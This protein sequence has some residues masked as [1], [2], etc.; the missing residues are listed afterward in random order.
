[1]FIEVVVLHVLGTMDS[2]WPLL[3]QRIFVLTN[4]FAEFFDVQMYVSI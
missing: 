1:M 4:E 3:R 2:V